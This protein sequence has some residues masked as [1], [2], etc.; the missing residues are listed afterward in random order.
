MLRHEA[1]QADPEP[2]GYPL[3]GFEV[4]IARSDPDDDTGEV[5]VSGPTMMHGYWRAE[6]GFE[7]QNA[8]LFRTGDLGRMADN[9]LI[10]LKG[11]LDDVFKVGAEK[12]DRHSIEKTLQPLLTGCEFC[13]LPVLH[14]VF[15][16]TPAL[17]VA[18]K[19]RAPLP[20]RAA[21]IQ[22]IRRELPSR[23]V[24][25]LMLWSGEALPRLLNGKT[26]YQQLIRKFQTLPNLYE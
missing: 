20:S 25:S 3:P 11:R 7:P 15:G 13:V 1:R 24:P 19:D 2:A 6:R 16:Q 18:T 8:E 12:V 23:F 17:F 14:P 22:A 5:C 9:G 26:D 4:A 21:L 10:T